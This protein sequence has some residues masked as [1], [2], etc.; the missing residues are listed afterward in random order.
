MA[1]KETLFIAPDEL[2][3]EDAPSDFGTSSL[4]ALY[5]P[6]R[7]RLLAS[8]KAGSKTRPLPSKEHAEALLEGLKALAESMDKRLSPKSQVYGDNRVSFQL[9][10]KRTRRKQSDEEKAAATAKRVATLAAKR[11]EKQAAAEKEAA[12]K[13]QQNGQQTTPVPAARTAPTTARKAVPSGARR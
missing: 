1:D 8:E 5:E 13:E 6:Y 11:A 2:E 7:E 12:E 9:V 10:P 4:A 3:F